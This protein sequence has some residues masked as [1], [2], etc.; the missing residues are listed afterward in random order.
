MKGSARAIMSNSRAESRELF[1]ALVE[2]MGK[3]L[4]NHIG[5]NPWGIMSNR[6]KSPHASPIMEPSWNRL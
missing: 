5:S 1:C 3:I 6:C 4:P 2:V